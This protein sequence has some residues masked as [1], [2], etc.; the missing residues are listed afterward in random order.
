[1][2]A[3]AKAGG[4]DLIVTREVCRFMRNA[5]LTLILVDELVKGEKSSMTTYAID[6]EQAATVRKIYEM[7]L[8][9]N[10]LKKI[11]KFL[12]A[13]DALAAEQVNYKTL[14]EAAEISQPTAKEWVRLLQ[15]LG[16]ICMCEE[17]IP[18][19]SKNCFIPCNLI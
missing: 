8:Q 12:N 11:K 10:G 1:M 4:C 2:I 3:R 16:I 6:E 5:K 15:G 19:D 7:A 18:I 9:G 14:A 13:C 17:I